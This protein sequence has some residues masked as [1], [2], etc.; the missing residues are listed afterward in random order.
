MIMDFFNALY[1]ESMLDT[2]FLIPTWSGCY[3][4]VVASLPLD[5]ECVMTET[6]GGERDRLV[7]DY[8]SL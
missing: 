3:T 6:R 8:F 5:G 1:Y 4:M 2:L 7:C